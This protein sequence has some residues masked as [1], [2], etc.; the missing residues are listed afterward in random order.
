MW[1]VLPDP[2]VGSQLGL[3]S[4]TCAMAVNGLRYIDL[5]SSMPE[6]RCSV[7]SG[8]HTCR[9]VEKMSCFVYVVPAAQRYAVCAVT[10]Q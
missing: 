4:L 3:E 1:R 10:G 8:K 5:W 9:S 6:H 7:A 2:Q